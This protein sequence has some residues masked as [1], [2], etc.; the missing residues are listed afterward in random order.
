M[1]AL[2]RKDG[3]EIILD[4]GDGRQVRVIVS[5]SQRGKAVLLFDGPD[6]VTI[7][8]LEAWQRR[9]SSARLHPVEVV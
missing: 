6:S 8:R 7:D 4:L 5:R 2:G 3:E 9:Q 1:L